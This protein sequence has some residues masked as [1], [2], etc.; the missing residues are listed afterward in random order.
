MPA[1]RALVRILVAAALASALF[2]CAM[3]PVPADLPAIALGQSGLYRLEVGLFVFYGS[4]LLVTPAFSG[5]VRGRLPIEI[6]TRGAKF[7]EEAGH[8]ALLNEER[9]KDLRRVT[10]GLVEGLRIANLEIG[11]LKEDPNRDNAIPAVGSER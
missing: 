9:I 3:T 5:L 1:Q 4:L 2:A 8:S 11:R 10:D 7:A 6:S